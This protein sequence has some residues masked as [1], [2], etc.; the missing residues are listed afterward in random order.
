M[1]LKLN[2]CTFSRRLANENKKILEATMT[3]KNLLMEIN[4]VRQKIKV[5]QLLSWF[6]FLQENSS[7]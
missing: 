1:Q 2:S 6:L 7:I 5:F 4:I 3:T